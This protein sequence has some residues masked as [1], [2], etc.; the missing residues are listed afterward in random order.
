MRRY[1]S[2]LD[3][4]LRIICTVLSWLRKELVLV[5][6]ECGNRSSHSME[7]LNFLTN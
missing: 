1:G 4:V 5:C 7:V 2:M 6:Y 3:P